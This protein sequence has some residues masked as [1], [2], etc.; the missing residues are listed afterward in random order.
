MRR[1]QHSKIKVANIFTILPLTVYIDLWLQNT[2]LLLL[3]KSKKYPKSLGVSLN[4]FAKR[5]LGV[6]LERI[7]QT[8]P[9]VTSL[10]KDMLRGNRQSRKRRGNHLANSLNKKVG[11]GFTPNRF[12]WYFS[13]L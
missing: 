4:E 12:P 2:T 3:G 8:V 7:R 6:S 10:I 1:Y 11:K 9:R 5:S 13:F